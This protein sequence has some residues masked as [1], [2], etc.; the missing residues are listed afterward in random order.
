MRPGHRIYNVISRNLP[1]PA[2]QEEA[3]RV[4]EEERHERAWGHLADIDMGPADAPADAP[5][6]DPGLLWITGENCV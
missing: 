1:T 4:A 5:D 3:Q 2:S 6:I